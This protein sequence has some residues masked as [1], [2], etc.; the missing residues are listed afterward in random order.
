[1]SDTSITDIALAAG[2]SP[3]TVSRALQNHPRISA[4][5]RMAIQALARD[6]GYRP[7]QVA[8]SL[9]TGRT[10]TLGVVIT[11]VTDPFVAEVM[12]GA[13]AASREAGYSLLFAMSNR[14]PAQE[15]EAAQILA[16]REVDGMIVISS[17]ATQLYEDLLKTARSRSHLPVVLINNGQPGAHVHSVCMNNMGSALHAVSYLY[18]LGHRRIAFIAGPEGGRS[19]LERL[20]GY[21]QG[22]IT[23]HLRALTEYIIPGEGQPEDGPRALVA[24]MDLPTPPSAVLCYNDLAAIGLL[25]AARDAGLRVPVDVS[26]VGFDNLPLGAYTSPPLTTVDQPKQVMGTRAVAMCLRALAGESAATEILDGV[27]VVRGSAGPASS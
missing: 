4:E 6:M 15:I 19:S 14:D 1:M 2:V 18:N 26:V 13:E 7:S 24:L 3:S 27:L 10:R 21:Q 5:R 11:D 17:R 25:A 20:E 8:R 23:N 12:K 16:D 9:V 22:L